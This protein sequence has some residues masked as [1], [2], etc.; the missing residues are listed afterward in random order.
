MDAYTVGDG[1]RALVRRNWTKID[2][3]GPKSV[4][5]PGGVISYFGVLGFKDFFT[6]ELWLIQKIFSVFKHHQMITHLFLGD[7][8]V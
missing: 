4:H 1:N 5:D 6:D 7:W 2:L 3:C 8:D